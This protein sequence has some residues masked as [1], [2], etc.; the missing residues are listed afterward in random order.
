MLTTIS[1]ASNASLA[2]LTLPSAT[3]ISS[4]RIG[5]VG[6]ALNQGATF[7]AINAAGEASIYVQNVLMDGGTT[8]TVPIGGPFG[9]TGWEYRFPEESLLACPASG[10]TTISAAWNAT[11]TFTLHVGY[12]PVRK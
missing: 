6:V 3:T 1:V 2:T 7:P 12:T 8:G 11:T 9:C 4:Y 10:I 5:L